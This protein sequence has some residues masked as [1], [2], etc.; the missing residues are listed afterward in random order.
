MI[1]RNKK[2]IAA[3][4]CCCITPSFALDVQQIYNLAMNRS[5]S[6]KAGDSTRKAVN[7]D[8]S[9][10]TRSWLPNIEAQGYFNRGNYDGGN[11]LTRSDFDGISVIAR[12]TLFDYSAIA[13]AMGA[14]YVRSLASYKFKIV[15]QTEIVKSINAYFDLL[16]SKHLVG[17]AN[18][19]RQMYKTGL[20]QIR[21]AKNLNLKTPD[22]VEFVQSDY[23][24][25]I[26]EDL[27]A[28]TAYSD[29]IALLE[30]MIHQKVN[31][32][33][34]LKTNVVRHVQPVPPLSVWEQRARKNNIAIRALQ[35]GLQIADKDIDAQV[36]RHL[37]QVSAV[38]SYNVLHNKGVLAY[39]GMAYGVSSNQS[40]HIHGYSIGIEATIPLFSGGTV[41]AKVSSAEQKRQAVLYKIAQVESDVALKTRTDYFLLKTDREK[42]KA[43]RR[44][45]HA[46]QLAV[47]ATREQMKAHRKTELDLMKAQAK[48][49][50][51]Q[52]KYQESIFDYFKRYIALHVDAGELNGAVIYEVNQYI[53]HN[54]RIKIT[55]NDRFPIYLH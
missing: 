8:A 40:N 12:Q 45:V 21:V 42:V 23:E 52:E 6:V 36:G 27:K 55:Q 33:N 25:A 10:A 1:K 5:N 37:P 20:Y 30:N 19:N 3:L 2:I 51:A 4:L 47:H 44:A 54:R 39:G 16:L 49:G 17:L 34:P 48:L 28:R 29:S 46:S 13:R 11:T 41:S 22:E 50:L 38:G 7:D 15:K 53:D 35:V 14:K 18:L 24:D 43:Q 26:A 32:I 31:Y 9:V